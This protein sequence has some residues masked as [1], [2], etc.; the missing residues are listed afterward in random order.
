MGANVEATGYTDVVSQEINRIA[1]IVRELL[2][3]HRPRVMEFRSLNLIDVLEDVLV[4]MERK[5]QSR[6]V[7]TVKRVETEIPLVKGSP[8]N[9]KQVFIN[10]VINAADAMADGGQLTVSLARNG[11]DVHIRFEDSGPGI[12]PEIIPRIFEPF[13]TTKEPGKGTGLGLAVCYG[14]MKKHGRVDRIL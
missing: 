2:D 1:G 11:T 9:L 4:L 10:I 7:Q 6:G 12:D 14:I 5:L 8:E 13:F 3:F